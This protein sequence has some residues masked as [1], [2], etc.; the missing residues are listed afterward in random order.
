M[1]QKRLK[2]ISREI[3]VGFKVISKGI[4]GKFQRYFKEVS[5]V[6]KIVLGV[7]GENF[8]KKFQWCF[9][10]VFFTILLLQGFHRSYPSRR[11]ARFFGG[12]GVRL[13]MR[14]KDIYTFVWVGFVN[15][16]FK[17]LPCS[18]L[19]NICILASFMLWSR[20]S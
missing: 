14:N 6:L 12:R 17:V 8:K 4:L 18:M 11:R 19:N 20:P 1:F 3:S 15:L 2:G 7:F 5:R 13:T 9:K 16:Y 10:N